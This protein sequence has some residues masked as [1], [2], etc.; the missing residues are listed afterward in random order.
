MNDGCTTVDAKTN[1]RI[2]NAAL[3]NLKKPLGRSKEEHNIEKIDVNKKKASF[4]KYII[5]FFLYSFFP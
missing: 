3:R 2:K 4:E 1:P 5:I